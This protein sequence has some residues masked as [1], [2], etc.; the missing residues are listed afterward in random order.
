MSLKTA[1]SNFQKAFID[2]N[3][4]LTSKFLSQLAKY[5][6]DRS[7]TRRYD[8]IREC[9]N[10]GK[11]LASFLCRNDICDELVIEMLK[12]DIPF[13]LVSNSK[14]EYGFIIRS[15]DRALSNE[16]IKAVLKKLGN[17][18]EIVTGDELIAIVQKMREKD[19]G[20]IAINGLTLRELKLLEK[21]CKKNGCL[22]F[23]SEDKMSDNSY[24]FMAHG[25]QAVSEQ[26]FP[27][28]IFE[29]I[30]MTEGSCKDINNKRIEN[31]IKASDLKINNFGR[32]EGITAP[33]YI[34]GSGN[35][36]MTIEQSGFSFGY[37]VNKRNGI[38]F[39]Q[40]F[41]ANKDMPGFKEYE[42]T[43]YNRIPN[44][45][46]TTDRQVFE[47]HFLKGRNERD[48][49]DF[50]MNYK[51]RSAFFGE[52][53]LTAAIMQVVI[54]NVI[55]DDIMNVS[56][57]W[58]EKTEHTVTEA[59]RVL[60]GLIN[61]EIPS[62][63]DFS[64]LSEIKMAISDYDINLSDYKTVAENL[65]GISIT[66]ERGSLEIKGD[67][68]EHSEAMYEEQ[69]NSREVTESIEVSEEIDYSATEER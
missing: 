69:I 3:K 39:E 50:G 46:I 30:M 48:S 56:G 10:E 32:K 64:D 9:M 47:E 68:Y 33:I 59:G 34:V 42:T 49:L 36:Y 19:K 20:L 17:Y 26:N 55:N 61:N 13:V 4:S 60:N 23:I 21:L 5:L 63:Y 58:M 27:A 28:M 7:G 53:I 66:N 35:Q 18:C 38:S 1:Q 24:R 65:L 43:F 31:E 52:K 14:G 8:M 51:E 41:A 62:G 25:R 54:R 15:E 45:A 6:K 22:D 67:I 40:Q 29:M 2:D 57:R 11:A 12:R 44:P 16:A 37:A